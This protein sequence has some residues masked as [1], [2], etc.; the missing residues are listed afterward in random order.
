MRPSAP[1]RLAARATS[2]PGGPADGDGTMPYH[3]PNRGSITDDATAG[4]EWN[5]SNGDTIAAN[6]VRSASNEP[7]ASAMDPGESY[8]TYGKAPTG[9]TCL[10]VPLN[11]DAITHPDSVK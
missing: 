4:P 11:A 7:F 6:D 9:P 10:P 8:S 2:D 3:L 1:L 5:A